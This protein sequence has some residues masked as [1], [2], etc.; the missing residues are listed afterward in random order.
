MKKSSPELDLLAAMLPNGSGI[1]IQEKLGQ[2]DFVESAT[3]PVDGLEW[4]FNRG[5]RYEVSPKQYLESIGFVFGEIDDIF[6]DVQLPEGWKIKPSE[7]SMWSYM[8]DAN[9]NERAGIFYKA[10][11]YDRSAH[12]DLTNRYHISEVYEGYE[13]FVPNTIKHHVFDKA[14]SSE[15]YVTPPY[16]FV[17][18]YDDDYWKARDNSENDARAWIDENYPDYRNPM[19]Y[20]D[21]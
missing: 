15:V 16:N 2:N 6:I 21:E 14:T 8:E 18:R 5:D 20:W 4:R 3:L 11:F 9:G 7:H 1:E 13:S 17:E 12:F 19:A 10:A